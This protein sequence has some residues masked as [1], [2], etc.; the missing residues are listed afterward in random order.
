MTAYRGAARS[1]RSRAWVRARSR[2]A[3]TVAA[4]AMALGFTAA[5]CDVFGTAAAKPLKAAALT[6]SPA[7][8]STGVDPGSPLTVAVAHGKVRTVVVTSKGDPV[9]GELVNGGTQ[10]RATQPLSVSTTYT[11]TAV[12]VGQ[13]HKKIT[14]TS[15]FSTLKPKH[16]FGVTI[17]NQNQQYGIGMPIMLSFDR[18]I[19]NRAAV[20]RA[21]NVTTS[22]PIVGSWYWDGDQSVVFRPKTWWKPGTKVSFFGRFNGVE[23]AKGVYGTADL[24]QSFSIGP[25][26]VV[27]ANTSTHYMDVYYKGK[28]FAHW[29]ISTG[30]PG[31]DTYNG[32][33]LT[34]EKANPTWMK[35]PGYALWVYDAVRFTWSGDYI[36]SAPWSVYEQ[37]V[38]N[39]SHGCVNV[40][41]DHAATYYSM[42]VPGDPVIVTGSPVNGTWGNGWTEWFLSWSQLLAGSALHAGVQ[43]GPDGSVFV[44]AKSLLPYQV[45]DRRGRLTQVGTGG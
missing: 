23:G 14:V 21:L 28:H 7:S 16:T 10:W 22:V 24:S 1:R 15:S 38:V 12:A 32:K 33:F 27:K 19:T 34:I 42:A 11:V 37:G 8:G 31:D 6:I 2:G 30:R 26:L 9:T 40:A 13:N 44:A 20:E 43:A 18:P 4:C 41:P 36:H 5:G 39:V 35:G 17:F 29:P 45:P 25:S 3:I